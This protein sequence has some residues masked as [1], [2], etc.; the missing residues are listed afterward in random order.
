MDRNG[1]D[2]IDELGI[3]EEEQPMDSK[4]IREKY[5]GQKGGNS[6]SMKKTNEE[7]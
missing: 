1:N 7:N 4:K 5:K 2:D 3:R 6:E